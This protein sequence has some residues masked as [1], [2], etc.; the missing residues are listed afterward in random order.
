[1]QKTSNFGELF[2]WYSRLWTKWSKHKHAQN[3]TLNTL[4][5]FMKATK[6]NNHYVTQLSNGYLNSNS[7]VNKL[8]VYIEYFSSIN[9]KITISWILTIINDKFDFSHLNNK[10]SQKFIVL[11]LEPTISRSLNS[12]ITKQIYYSKRRL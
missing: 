7:L 4:F 10:W 9:V 6:S 2:H 12:L 8:Q 5:L 3:T 1:M 11:C